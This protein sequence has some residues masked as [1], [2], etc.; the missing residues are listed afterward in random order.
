MNPDNGKK[1]AKENNESPDPSHWKPIRL[2][3]KLKFRKKASFRQPSD[4]GLGISTIEPGYETET[5]GSSLNSNY[6][7]GCYFQFHDYCQHTTLH[8]FRYIT[9]TTLKYSFQG[10]NDVIFACI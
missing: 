2:S 8:G 10:F 6:N 9:G 5:I 1:E 3:G 7:R 4:P